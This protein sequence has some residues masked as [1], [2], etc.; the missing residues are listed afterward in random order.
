MHEITSQEYLQDLGNIFGFINA[1]DFAGLK[2]YWVAKYPQ[3]YFVNAGLL[4]QVSIPAGVS[5]YAGT[6]GGTPSGSTGG[7]SYGNGLTGF[8][9]LRNSGN[10]IERYGTTTTGQTQKHIISYAEALADA[11]VKVFVDSKDLTGLYK[12]WEGKFPNGYILVDELKADLQTIANT[13]SGNTGINGGGYKQSFLD[14]NNPDNGVDNVTDDRSANDAP[15]SKTV[16]WIIGIALFYLI[17][18]KK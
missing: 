4:Q 6:G 10:I 7:S 3:G 5:N 13:I 1:Q 14:K 18:L 8:G 2:A 17:F 9:F 15:K 16:Y 12:Y 11:N